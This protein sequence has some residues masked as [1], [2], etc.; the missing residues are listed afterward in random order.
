MKLKLLI[1][2]LTLG[3][4]TAESTPPNIIFIL[5]DDMGYG[6]VQCL[7]PERGKIK[8]P[9]MDRLAQEGMIFTDAHTTSSVCTP[10]RYSLMTGRYNW[11]T[12]LQDLVTWGYSKA[13]ISADTLT[14]GQ[15]LQRSGYQTAMIGKWH[16]GMTLPTT[17]GVL[18]TGR[19]ARKTTLD[20]KG[21][22]E[23]GPADRGFDYFFGIAASLDM[24]PYIYIENRHF[25]G[26]A[27]NTKPNAPAAGFKHVDV[28]PE[29]GRR[30]A[31]YITNHDGQKPFFLYVPLTSPHTPIVPTPE[32]RGKSGINLYADFQMQ[33]D[34]IVG[35]ITQAVDQAGIADNTLIIVSADNGCS[36][37]ANF[38]ALEKAGHFASAQYRGS[39]A[40]LWEGGLRVP[41]I[42]RWPQVIKP[43]SVCDQTICLTDFLATCAEISG[44]DI[45][46]TQAP[47]SVS[48]LPALKGK[49]IVSSRKGIVSHSIS[50]HFAYRMGDWKL[51]L[52]KGSGG[53]T[54]PR[55]HEIPDGAPKA[56]LYNLAEDPGEQ[57][58][59]YLEKPEI[60]EKLYAQLILEIEN[61]RSTAGPKLANDIPND[62]IKLWK[63]NVQR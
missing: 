22:I 60:A 7:N 38:K 50:G 20:W 40:D 1:T 16:I 36:K 49:E 9:H 48:F 29:F 27:D 32:W 45:P 56:Q 14:V 15:A 26:E 23:E 57:N 53:W 58:N 62:Q 6:D 54:S 46:E 11:R 17:D 25:I 5:A 41:F 63:G 44:Y 3:L 59:L 47:D 28:L 42:V 35:Q 51:L 55:E 37:A 10:T 18:P 8:T 39:K 4:C 52:A 34:H 21:K 33:T 13:L 12:E 19:N 2:L 24:A 61:G 43:Q 31:E 30:S